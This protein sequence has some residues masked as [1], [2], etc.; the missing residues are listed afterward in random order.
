MGQPKKNKENLE[1]LKVKLQSECDNNEHISRVCTG[2]QAD[3][4]AL[5]AELAKIKNDN[6]LA[7]D[8]SDKRLVRLQYQVKKLTEIND[9]LTN[10]T[11]ELEL[12]AKLQIA[13]EGYTEVMIRNGKLTDAL[14]TLIKEKPSDIS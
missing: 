13:T 9:Q 8:D 6:Y 1:R 5:R 12:K 7:G 4:T 14:L 3:N 2:I 10:D 11:V